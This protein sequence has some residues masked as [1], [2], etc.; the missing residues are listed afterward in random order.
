MKLK[1]QKQLLVKMNS[2]SNEK[3]KMEIAKSERAGGC[4]RKE[5]KKK[6]MHCMVIVA[7]RKP[8]N[9]VFYCFPSHDLF[10]FSIFNHQMVTNV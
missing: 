3:E 2:S 9:R 1:L 5:K 6:T 8:T 4:E 10:H 7:E